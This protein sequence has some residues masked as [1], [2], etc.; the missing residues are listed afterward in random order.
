MDLTKLVPPVLKISAGAINL[1]GIRQYRSPQQAGAVVIDAVA[2][3]IGGLVST[4]LSNMR[5]SA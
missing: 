5:Y 4:V 2:A 1:P 3:A